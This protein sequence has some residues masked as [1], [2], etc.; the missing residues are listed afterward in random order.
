MKKPMNLRKKEYHYE[1]D[2]TIL[3]IATVSYFFTIFSASIVIRVIIEG[4]SEWSAYQE[5]S[6]SRHKFP[7]FL[8][9]GFI[10]LQP[11]KQNDTKKKPN[12]NNNEQKLNMAYFKCCNYLN[13]NWP[14]VH[15]DLPIVHY[16]EQHAV[17][18]QH[19]ERTLKQNGPR[20]HETHSRRKARFWVPFPQGGCRLCN[21]RRLCLGKD[22]FHGRRGRKAEAKQSSVSRRFR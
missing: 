22:P 19:I 6:L 10:H 8:N 9:M 1:L 12:N 11:F 15:H 4:F 5:S 7:Y 20:I 3:L 21:N 16:Q 13:Y 2:P 14:N 18:Q 17:I